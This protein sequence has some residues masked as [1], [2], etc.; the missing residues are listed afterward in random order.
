M[1]LCYQLSYIKSY[2]NFFAAVNLF[3]GGDAELSKIAMTYFFCNISMQALSKTDDS[4]LLSFQQLINLQQIL[5][6]Y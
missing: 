6:P 1:T 3:L 2:I 4:I 5:R